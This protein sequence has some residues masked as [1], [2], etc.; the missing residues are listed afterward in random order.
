MA[1][2]PFGVPESPARPPPRSLP[3][4]TLQAP[5]RPGKSARRC[6][7]APESAGLPAARDRA[8]ALG[9]GVPRP[10]GRRRQRAEVEWTLLRHGAC[11]GRY[12]S[13]TAVSPQSFLP[14]GG[15]LAV[16]HTIL[17]A[18]ASL[19]LTPASALP[20]TPATPTFR[21]DTVPSPGTAGVIRRRL[22]PDSRF[23]A[24]LCRGHAGSGRVR[25]RP[26][27]GASARVGISGCEM[28]QADPG[29][30]AP[31][32]RCRPQGGAG[33]QDLS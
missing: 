4:N 6:F 26:P 31:E 8:V 23:R 12:R 19:R 27:S 14:G 32:A 30:S 15:E 2:E 5:P 22:G 17:A 20:N 10:R 3:E 29:P 16:R 7:P 33:C 28:R 18:F 1:G 9:R 21:S 11:V 24:P 25:E 13:S